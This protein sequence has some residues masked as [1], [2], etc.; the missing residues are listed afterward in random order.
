MRAQRPRALEA[1]TLRVEDTTG[2]KSDARETP[3]RRELV[4]RGSPLGV[5]L[6]EVEALV[7]YASRGLVDRGRRDAASSARAEWK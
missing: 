5:G 2:L 7:R 3:S 6:R 4:L 1:L